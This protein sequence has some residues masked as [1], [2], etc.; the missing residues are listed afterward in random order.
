MSSDRVGPLIVCKQEDDVRTIRSVRCT[1]GYDECRQDG[2]DQEEVESGSIRFHAFARFR[3]FTQGTARLLNA[4]IYDVLMGVIGSR[5]VAQECVSL[6][7]H[8]LLVAGERWW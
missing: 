5:E 1:Y 7:L 3:V 6:L 8:E 4:T 2:C